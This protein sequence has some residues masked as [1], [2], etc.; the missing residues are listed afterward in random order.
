PAEPSASDGFG[1]LG[2][3]DMRARQEDEEDADRVQLTATPASKGLDCPHVYVMGM[4]EEILPHRSSIEAGTVDEE[5]R[6][7]YV[8]ITR[9]KRNLTFTFAARRRQFGEIIDCLPSRFLDELPQE[10][11]EWEGTEDVPVEQKQAR[12]NSALADIRSLLGR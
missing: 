11:L 9:A 8:A 2:Q 4:E 3:R 12:G 10:D 6:L 5:R 7:A 1:K